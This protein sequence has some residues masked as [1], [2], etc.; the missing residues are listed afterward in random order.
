MLSKCFLK[1]LKMKLLIEFKFNKGNR[2][3]MLKHVFINYVKKSH[4]STDHIPEARHIS[5]NTA[6]VNSNLK[7]KR[8]I[9]KYPTINTHDYVKIYTKDDGKYTSQENI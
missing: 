1:Q 6:N 4:S 7:F 2:T 8:L 9:E 5:T 3:D